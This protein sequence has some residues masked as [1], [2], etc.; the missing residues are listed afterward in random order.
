MFM[1]KIYNEN[2]RCFGRFKSMPKKQKYIV[3]SINF[4]WSTRNIKLFC[5]LPLTQCFLLSVLLKKHFQ[6]YF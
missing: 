1:D 2:R 3:K 5:A 4:L 6:M